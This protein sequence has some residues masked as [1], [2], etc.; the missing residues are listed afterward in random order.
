MYVRLTTTGSGSNAGGGEDGGHSVTF[1][2]SIPVIIII[3]ICGGICIG[4][5]IAMIGLLLYRYRIIKQRRP[6]IS[7]S[8]GDIDIN[9]DG[10]MTEMTFQMS[11]HHKK[12]E[13]TEEINVGLVNMNID[14]PLNIVKMDNLS[15][16]WTPDG[17]Q[18]SQEP[19]SSQS[20]P[21]SQINLHN[22]GNKGQRRND[23]HFRV[24][25]NES[26]Q[27][28]ELF[29]PREDSLG[30]ATDGTRNSD[31]DDIVS[32]KTADYIA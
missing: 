19:G 14:K 28:E 20:Q 2:L 9:C 22:D 18:Q 3:C 30:N 13:P 17:S 4:I 29:T 15:P 25:S 24:A 16:I 31:S 1:T 27:A 23:N 12:G 32:M 6:K 5:C 8:G 7:T 11:K 21:V 10:E 26:V